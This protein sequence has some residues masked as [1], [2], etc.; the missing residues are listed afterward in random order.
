MKSLLIAGCAALL[1]FAAPAQVNGSI[2]RNAPTVMHSITMGDNKLEV[3]YTAIRFG[4]GQWQQILDNVDSHERFN[5]MAM[6]RPIGSVKSSVPVMA[7]GK[8]V[9]AGEYSMY[10]TVHEG[11]GWV[12]NLKPAEGE[13]IRWRLVLQPSGHENECMRINLDPSA[14]NGACMLSIAF[15]EQMV[16]VPVKVRAEGEKNG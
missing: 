12:L 11:A 9:P 13:A 4:Q 7:A 5:E 14:E 2:N 6:K 16:S 1:A 15:G 8:M 10:F 3:S